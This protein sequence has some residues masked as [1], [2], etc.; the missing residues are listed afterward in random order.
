MSVRLQR[1]RTPAL[2]E[3]KYLLHSEWTRPVACQDLC[4][5][6]DTC[7]CL[8]RIVHVD[9]MKQWWLR[10]PDPA[11]DQ[12]NLLRVLDEIPSG[13]YP[14]LLLNPQKLF[15]GKPTSL[16]V[17]SLLLKLDRGQLIDCFYDSGIFDNDLTFAHHKSLRENLRRIIPYPEVDAVLQDFN[18][19]KWQFCP[20]ALSLN[21]SRSLHDTRFIPPFCHKI[22]MGDNGGTASVYCIAVQKDLISDTRLCIAIE[23]SLYE[24]PDFGPVRLVHTLQAETLY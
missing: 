4:D 23:D 7:T 3:F 24:D 9:A 8:R 10:K 12:S 18:E 20:L 1:R 16:V 22:K 2:D 11:S 6:P 17:F 15:M 21:M 19:Q 5:P 13:D 14:R